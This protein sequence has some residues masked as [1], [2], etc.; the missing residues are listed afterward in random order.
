MAIFHLS[1][2]VKDFDDTRHFYCT[3]LDGKQEKTTDEWFNVNVSGHQLTF[4]FLPAEV[5]TSPHLHWGLVIPWDKFHQLYDNL[6]QHAIP[7]KQLPDYQETGT[8]KERVKMIFIDPSGYLIEFKAY[9]HELQQ[10]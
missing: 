10:F 3:I 5:I 1:L 7:F 2:P 8:D 9:K 6:K 4:H